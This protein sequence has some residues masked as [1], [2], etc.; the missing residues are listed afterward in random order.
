[1]S[2]I[3]YAW[4]LAGQ[5][6]VT[7]A[8]WWPVT[9]FLAFMA[10]H[11]IYRDGLTDDQQMRSLPSVLVMFPVLMILW[12]ALAHIEPDDAAIVPWRLAVL[13][14]FVLLQIVATAAIISISRTHRR[15]TVLFSV[16]VGWV[17]L[18]SAAL[19]AM[20]LSGRMIPPV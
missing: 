18:V 12:G 17:A 7:L 2:I 11:S 13:G 15:Q 5:V 9:G 10:A 16:F 4:W 19:S 1:M 8:I 14:V 3:G 6:A 20:A